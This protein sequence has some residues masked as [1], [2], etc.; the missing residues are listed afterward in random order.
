MSNQSL[1]Q[2]IKLVKEKLFF[3]IG[4][5]NALANYVHVNDVVKALIL[6]PTKSNALG[7]VFIISQTITIEQMIE[8]LQC[9]LGFK[10]KPF[11][12]SER[13]IRVLLK[14]IN[15]VYSSFPLTESRVDALTNRCRYNSA[16]L[17]SELD[18]K[19]DS[20]LEKKFDYFSS[21]MSH[22]NK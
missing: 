8:S 11:R 9:G 10:S 2:L 3:Y 4:K 19:F 20:S 14:I 16:K 21:K 13:L 7:N 6:C 12:L 18:F 5:P 15:F 1:F 17:E 22:E